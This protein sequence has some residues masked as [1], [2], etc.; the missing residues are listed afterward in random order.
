MKTTSE[1]T[2][3]PGNVLE[4]DPGCFIT[5]NLRRAAIIPSMGQKV[6]IFLVDDHGNLVRDVTDDIA[7]SLHLYNVPTN[8]GWIVRD[9]GQVIDYLSE[10][11]YEDVVWC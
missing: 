4:T 8:K 1:I 6:P 9:N 5:P 10:R 11:K 3:T 2:I 7:I